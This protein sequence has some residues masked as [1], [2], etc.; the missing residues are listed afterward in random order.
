MHLGSWKHKSGELRSLSYLELADELP[1][2]LKE[3]GLLMLNFFLLVNIHT[4]LLR[5]LQVTG[6]YAPTHR[7]GTPGRISSLG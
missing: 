3:M 2:Y 5:S 7:Y 4:G 6:F 1:K